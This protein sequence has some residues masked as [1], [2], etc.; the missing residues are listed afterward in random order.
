MVPAI[1]SRKA[2]EEFFADRL[3]TAKVTVSTPEGRNFYPQPLGGE[4]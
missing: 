2:G 3:I 4:D 1:E